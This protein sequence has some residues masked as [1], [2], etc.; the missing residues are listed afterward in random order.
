MLKET[1]F[2]GIGAYIDVQSE[3]YN[4]HVPLERRITYLRGDSGVGKSTMVTF[5]RGAIV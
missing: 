5:I 3:L 4:I 1:S 2:D